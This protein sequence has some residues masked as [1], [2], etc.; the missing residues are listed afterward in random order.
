MTGP[1]G[2]GKSV[3][4]RGIARGLE[5]ED[6]ITSPTFTLICEYSGK[7]PLYHMDL[8]RISDAD[9]FEMIGGR[10]LIYSGG[11]SV[12]EWAEKIEE[13]LPEKMICVNIEIDH[14]GSRIITITGTEK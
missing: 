3:M 2:S 10:D 14:E 12:I 6:N 13:Y 7:L 4:T 11:I 1:I 9:E 8:Y 5:I